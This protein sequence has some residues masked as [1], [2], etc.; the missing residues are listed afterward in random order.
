MYYITLFM[1]ADLTNKKL[2]QKTTPVMST[3]PTK[4]YNNP[5][6]VTPF[7]KSNSSASTTFKPPLLADQLFK[8]L[9]STTFYIYS[10]RNVFV[11]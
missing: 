11:V 7:R 8:N 1:L 2:P 9:T 10:F 3:Q 5:T 6:I 4:V